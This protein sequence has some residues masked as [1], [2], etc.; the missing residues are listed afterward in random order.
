MLHISDP[1]AY[2][3]QEMEEAMGSE[4][5]DSVSYPRVCT[6]PIL[7]SEAVDDAQ[8][9]PQSPLH[10]GISSMEQHVDCIN[11]GTQTGTSIQ[12]SSPVL[13]SQ[14]TFTQPHIQTLPD[15]TASPFL[16][17]IRPREPPVFTGERG[18]DFISWLRTIEDYL[19]CISCS[20]QQAIVYVILLL[21]GDA[22]IWWD[23]AFS[24]RGNKR[25]ESLEE[26]KGLLRAQ[27]DSPIRESHARTKLLKLTQKKGEDACTY[28]ARTKSLLYRVPGFEE[29]T[30]LQLWI[31]GLRQPFRFEVAK[32][33]PETLAKAES[34]VARMEDAFSG[35]AESDQ[36]SKKNKRKQYAGFTGTKLERQSRD[37]NKGQG[38]A[39]HQQTCQKHP[40][41]CDSGYGQAGQPR[42][43]LLTGP[44]FHPGY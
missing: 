36:Q 27:F 3:W 20:E 23:A 33:A 15:H 13:R 11:T 40:Q 19:D 32:A 5:V 2:L 18:Q 9:Q 26:L 25:P 35:K 44:Y 10:A 6:G 42:P 29:K 37:R 14:W 4:A 28:M 31:F 24:S 7:V 17:H 41:D 43:S 21:A 12:Q 39:R 8:L 30:A 34:L 22:R 16:V 1:V 38:F